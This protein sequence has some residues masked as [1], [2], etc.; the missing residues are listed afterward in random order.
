[1][2]T[3]GVD[4]RPS[5]RLAQLAHLYG[6]EYSGNHADHS[7]QDLNRLRRT[8]MK[9]LNFGS[10]FGRNKQLIGLDIGS[11]AIKLVQMKEVNGKYFLQKFGMKPLE[12]EVIVDGTVMDAGRVVTVIKELLS[13]LNIK[14]KHAAISVS[15]HSVIVK[16]ISLP[17]MSDEELETEVK[18]AAEQYIPFDL[19]EVNLDFHI[20][21]NAE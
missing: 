16:K 18:V 14:L 12:P 15:G 2:G 8:F 1:M 5:Q 21:D 19:N 13:E 20:L 10:L 7:N 6:T 11:S 3:R 17:P 9:W 4:F